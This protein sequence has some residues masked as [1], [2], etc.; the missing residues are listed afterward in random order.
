M[1][2][3]HILV[4]GSGDETAGWLAERL[5]PRRFRIHVVEPGPRVIQA[6]REWQPAVAVLDGIDARPQQA[7]LEV[8]LLKDR[9]PGVSIIA[10]SRE[11]SERDA[12][13]VE[14]GVFCYLAGCSREELLRVVEAATEERPP[15]GLLDGPV[16]PSTR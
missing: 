6:I 1:S 2:R 13:V 3:T 14:Q 9:S 10:W 15:R 11:S 7:P 5:S 4:I 16:A 8:A 12:P